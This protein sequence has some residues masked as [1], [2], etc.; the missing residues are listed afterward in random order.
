MYVC[1]RW[2]DHTRVLRNGDHCNPP[3][4]AAWNK[5]GEQ[6]F[7]FIVVLEMHGA[8]AEELIQAE[9]L[10]ITKYRHICFNINMEPGVSPMLLESSRIKLLG[11]SC[12]AET[13]EKISQANLGRKLSEET[14]LKMSESRKG[15]KFSEEHRRK[16]VLANTGKKRTEDQ[17]RRIGAAKKGRKLTEEH[18]RKVG[19]SKLGNQC[20]L[21]YRHTKETKHKMSESH[22]E[23][24]RRRKLPPQQ[25]ALA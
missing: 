4:Q 8:T 23:Q 7:K 11:R 17:K 12:T 21:G 2:T 16:I 25:L 13:R 18:K 10:E 9:K 1:D 24:W 6:A 20:A 22:K 5:Y 19:I 14:R 3:L 15:L